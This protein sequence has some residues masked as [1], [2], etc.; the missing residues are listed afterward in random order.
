MQ[1][2][3]LRDAIRPSLKKGEPVSK[4]RF[5]WCV[6]KADVRRQ[7]LEDGTGTEEPVYGW[8]LK[9][10]A[11]AW[12]ERLPLYSD[13]VSMNSLACS[14]CEVCAVA[15]HPS[16]EKFKH[17]VVFDLEQLNLALGEDMPVHALYDPD[18]PDVPQNPC[19]FLVRPIGRDVDDL[20]E[21]I[22]GWS[23]TLRHH[24]GQ[25]ENKPFNPPKTPPKPGSP[26][27][28]RE[29]DDKARYEKVL[30]IAFNVWPPPA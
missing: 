5:G 15:L 9:E 21:A 28:I 29:L 17:L 14:R 8:V 12:T 13:G 1:D 24:K 19:H 22:K 30:L 23:E 4:G 2:E 7:F 3:C 16:A 10:K 26:E 25:D 6:V 18:P 11:L 27:A 20:A